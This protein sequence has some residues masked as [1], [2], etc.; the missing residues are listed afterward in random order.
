MR[1]KPNLSARMERCAHLLIPDP[2]KYRGRWLSEFGY[3]ELHIELG[4]GK[5]RFT[6][7]TAK[8]APGILLAAL[9]KS[10]DVMITALERADS[11]GLR[12]IRFINALADNLTDYFA[13]GEVSRIYINFCDPWPIGRHAK[14]RLTSRLFIELYKQVLRPGGEIL[15]KTDNRPL[16]DFSLEEFEFGGFAI[17]EVVHDLHKDGPAGIMTDYEVKFHEQGL[18]IFSAR[19][20]L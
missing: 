19:F 18:P 6:A 12:N 2:G 8:A 4:C 17:A 1:K 16:F 20:V 14:R 3:D 5:G 15:F 7:E 13:P 11:E 9:E 10:A